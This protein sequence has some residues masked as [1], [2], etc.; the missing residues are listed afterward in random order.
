MGELKIKVADGI[1]LEFRKQAM[2]VFGHKKG[3][4]SVAAEQAM[5]N[6]VVLETKPA[7]PIESLRG[8]LKHVKKSSVELQHELGKMRAERYS[9]RC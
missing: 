7:T 8:V 1:E 3:S 9:R 2:L 4:I 5:K 6:W